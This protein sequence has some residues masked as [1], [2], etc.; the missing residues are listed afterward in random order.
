MFL[1][2]ALTLTAMFDYDYWIATNKLHVD[3][4]HLCPASAQLTRYKRR[5]CCRKQWLSVGS[6]ST[7][8]FG[9][10]SRVT[11]K[12][13]SPH[14][15]M[16]HH[17]WTLQGDLV[18]T[19][20]SLVSCALL[21]HCQHLSPYILVSQPYLLHQMALNFPQTD[22]KVN[23]II[24]MVDPMPD[25]RENEMHLGMANQQSMKT[26]WDLG[27]LWTQGLLSSGH[28]PVQ[29]KAF[30]INICRANLSISPLQT[31][32]AIQASTEKAWLNAVGVHRFHLSKL[33]QVKWPFQ[34]SLRLTEGS[35]HSS[36]A[37][38]LLV[39]PY[40]NLFWAWRLDN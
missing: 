23:Y 40:F 24:V 28:F 2:P 17:P 9:F 31:V 14:I 11:K 27:D 21:S 15:K 38:F 37:L 3:F 36:V 16:P 13:F 1:L 6:S 18:L 30:P 7:V 12:H 5:H 25:E 32:V 20:Y 4:T 33:R 8:S 39:F 22:C 26:G 35:V 29:L 34:P 19:N 10:S